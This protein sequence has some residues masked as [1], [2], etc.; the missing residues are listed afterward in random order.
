MESELNRV[1]QLSNRDSGV[2]GEESDNPVMEIKQ[3]NTPVRL[4][5]SVTIASDIKPKPKLNQTSILKGSRTNQS[6]Q[7]FSNDKKLRDLDW[8]DL[9]SRIRY[10]VTD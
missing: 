5:K 10:I 4:S 7:K 3:K 9:E 6:N 2:S 1:K 8:A